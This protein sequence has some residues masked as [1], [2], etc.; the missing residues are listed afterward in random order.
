MTSIEQV[1][2]ELREGMD[3]AIAGGFQLTFG[4]W[5]VMYAPGRGFFVEQE[6]G[7]CGCALGAWA[8]TKQPFVP[9]PE[10]MNDHLGR[11]IALRLGAAVSEV[12]GWSTSELG[13]FMQ[14]WDGEV[15]VDLAEA[16]PEIVD[17]AQRLAAEYLLGQSGG[18]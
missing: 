17:L 14:A 10:R 15:D 8:I 13:A 6:G 3:A 9:E 12:F 2:R 4:I 18:V 5:G 16:H 1:E 11:H 7:G